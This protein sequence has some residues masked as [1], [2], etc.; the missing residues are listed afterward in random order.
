M[1]KYLEDLKNELIQ[2]NINDTD[3][4]DIIKDHEEMIEEALADGI[5]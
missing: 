2:K 4:K 3:I 5:I 1:K